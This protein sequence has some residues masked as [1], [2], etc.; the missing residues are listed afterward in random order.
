MQIE[1]KTDALFITDRIKQIDKHYYVVYSTKK[2]KYE[3]HHSSQMGGSYCLSCP[4]DV[5]DERFVDYV[6]KTRVEN[7]EKLFAEI[8][9]QNQKLENKNTKNI[10]EKIGE[11]L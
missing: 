4:Y 7:R 5:L 10:M 2:Q 8:E 3:L 6:Q 1:I 9:A 11:S